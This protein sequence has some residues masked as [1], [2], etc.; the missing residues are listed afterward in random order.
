MSIL[1]YEYMTDLKETLRSLS[2]LWDL[3][4]QLYDFE[5][6]T[7]SV[8]FTEIDC[9]DVLQMV[10]KVELDLDY[11]VT[12]DNAKVGGFVRERCRIL[13]KLMPLI[14]KLQSRKNEIT[15]KIAEEIVAVLGFDL[16]PKEGVVTIK[17]L[18]DH[19]ILA[20]EGE[21]NTIHDRAIRQY[22]IHKKLMLVKYQLGELLLHVDTDQ[23]KPAILKVCENDINVIIVIF[24]VY[25]FAIIV[26]IHSPHMIEIH[27]H[28][29]QTIVSPICSYFLPYP[30]WKKCY[31]SSLLT[32]RALK[33][34]L[35]A[36]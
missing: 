33:R 6:L 1:D 8:Y 32:Y 16:W 28:I 20:H 25:L 23:G 11:K 21:I 34:Q 9:D 5:L 18:M 30:N 15:D 22:H 35:T 14:C 12:Q 3:V 26:H 31:K 7:S 19:N 29:S 24:I 17:T 2:K 4:R 36:P 27:S 10:E 13:N